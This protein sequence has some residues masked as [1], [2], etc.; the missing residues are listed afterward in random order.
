MS[1]CKDSE[2][3]LYL[4]LVASNTKGFQARP[5]IYLSDRRTYGLTDEWPDWWTGEQTDRWRMDRW[6]DGGGRRE[7]DVFDPPSRNNQQSP[8]AGQLDLNMCVR[9][10]GV[11]VPWGFLAACQHQ[12]PPGERSKTLSL[13]PSTSIDLSRSYFS[14]SPPP[15]LPRSLSWKHS[16][17]LFLIS[18]TFSHFF[19][20]LPEGREMRTVSYAKQ[21]RREQEMKR[22]KQ[23][24]GEGGGRK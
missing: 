3:E 20:F 15:T 12:L 13:F 18:S 21:K 6:M 10:F 19:F 7:F 2:V 4:N 16:L 8:G 11:C 14:H 1:D 24:K 9:L 5:N 23:R 22:A 17:L